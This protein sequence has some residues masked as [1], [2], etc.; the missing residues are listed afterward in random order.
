MMNPAFQP[1]ALSGLAETI[2]LFK[3]LSDP[4]EVT[5]AIVA[6]QLARHEYEGR[7]SAVEHR[8]RVIT[9]GEAE[10]RELRREAEDMMKTAQEILDGAQFERTEALADRAALTTAQAEYRAEVR[11]FA[12]HAAEAAD[13]AA[14]RLASIEEAAQGVAVDRQSL[15]ADTL[16]FSRRELAL[17]QAEEA[18]SARVAAFVAALTSANPTEVA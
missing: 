14:A 9:T 6:I 16:Q 10:S 7:A 8:E 12:D 3:L 18:H 11:I 13:A 17:K 2:Q 1:A 4:G 15:D 5:K